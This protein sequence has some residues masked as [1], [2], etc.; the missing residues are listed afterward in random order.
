LVISSGAWPLALARAFA[1]A[2]RRVAT[3]LTAVASDGTEVDTVELEEVVRVV[4][5]RVVR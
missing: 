1:G 4:R 5:G 3:R 2:V